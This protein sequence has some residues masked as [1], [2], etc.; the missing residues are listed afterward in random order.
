MSFLQFPLQCF[1]GKKARF[2][3]GSCVLGGLRPVGT[4]VNVVET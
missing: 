4:M 3:Y 1:A 2:I